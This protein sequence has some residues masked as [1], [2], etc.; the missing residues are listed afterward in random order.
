MSVEKSDTV[1][2]GRHGTTAF[3][4]T[5]SVRRLEDPM[6]CELRIER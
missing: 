2:V 3:L 1:I 6:V 5:V 4:A